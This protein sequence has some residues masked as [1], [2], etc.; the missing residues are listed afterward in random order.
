MKTVKYNLLLNECLKKDLTDL[1]AKQKERLLEKFSYLENGIWDTGVR[2]KKLKGAGGGGKVIFEAR[3]DRG[4]RLIFTL[5]R[6]SEEV[7]IYIWGAVKHDDI[8]AAARSILPD[9]A[10]FLTFEPLEEED[11]NDV[12]FDDLPDA[13][14]T[15]ESI[16]EKVKEDYGSQ[17]WLDIRDEREWQRLLAKKHPDLFEIFLYLT[18][19]QRRVLEQVP[20]VLIS[21]T[22]GSGKTT[23]A[24]YMLLKQAYDGKRLLFLTCS[25]YLKDFSQRL[26]QGLTALPDSQSRRMKSADSEGEVQFAVLTELIQNIL[27]SRGELPAPAKEVTLREFRMIF[28]KHALSRKYDPELVWEEIRSIIK[29]A[30]PP[31]NL[32]R[33]RELGIGF[34]RSKLSAVQ[35]R[36]FT[37]ALLELKNM[38]FM[39]K[40]ERILHHH[41]RYPDFDSFIRSLMEPTVRQDPGSSRVVEEILRIL[42]AKQNRFERPLLSLNE[43]LNLGRKRAPNFLYDREDIY[44]IAE[45]Y[46]KQLEADNRYDEID[47]CRMAIQALDKDRDRFLWDVVVCDEIQDFSD[48]QL[49]L[50]FRLSRLPGNL[51]CAGDTRQIIN[52]SGFRWEEVKQRFFER[53][54]NVPDVHQLALNFRS[55]G[56]IV[57]LSNAL[58]DLKQ[59][60]VGLAG[61]E[62][63]EDWKFNGRPPFVFAG[64]GQEAMLSSLGRIAAGS[65]ILV[66]TGGEQRKLKKALGTELIFTVQEAKGLEFDTVLLWKFSAEQ[67]SQGV[68]RKIAGSRNLEQEHYP[69]V[70]YEIN[71][72]YVA[73]TRSRNTLIIYDGPESA[74]VWEMEAVKPLVVT[75]S[76]RQDLAQ[77]WKQ[78]STKKE[79]G[80]Q[81]QYFYEREYYSAA[82]ECFRNADNQKM[83]DLSRAWIL[84]AGGQAGDAAVLFELHGR[85]RE[86]AEQYEHAGDYQKAAEA[87]RKAKKYDR[88]RLCA[89][90]LLEASGDYRGAASQWIKLNQ[91]DKALKAWK[92]AEAWE[93][94]AQY[95]QKQRDFTDAAEYYQRARM[96]ADAAECWKKAKQPQKAADLFFKL[97]NYDSAEKLYRK[98]REHDKLL[99]CYQGMGDS[100]KEALELERR[101]D[102]A[103][104]LAAFTRFAGSSKHNATQLLQEADAYKTPRL[105]IKAALRL[106]AAGR[107]ED[108]ADKFFAIGQFSLARDEYVRCGDLQQAGECAVV[109]GEALSAVKLF[110]QLDTPELRRRSV[111][112]LNAHAFD[113]YGYD[114]SKANAIYK[115]AQNLLS[116]KEYSRAITRMMALNM[117]EDALEICDKVSGRDEEILEYFL[118]REKY[119]YAEKVLTK[120]RSLQV[121][122]Q[123]LKQI[124]EHVQL[125]DIWYSSGRNGNMRKFGISLLYCCYDMLDKKT[126]DELAEDLMI[127]YRS[128]PLI[129]SLPSKLGE[130]ALKANSINML[131]SMLFSSFDQETDRYKEFHRKVLGYESSLPEYQVLKM[132]A[133]PADSD[134]SALG[135]GPA[136]SRGPVQVIK[137]AGGDEIEKLLAEL[138]ATEKN[139]YL[140]KNSPIQY[141]KAVT[142]LMEIGEKDRAI[143]ILQQ[144][145][146]ITEAGLLLESMGDYYEA[147]RFYRDNKRYEDAVRCCKKSGDQVGLARIY[148]RM[149]R[150]DEAVAIWKKLKKT[151]E[152]ERVRRKITKLKAKGK[153]K[154]KPEPKPRPGNGGD[155]DGE[156]NDK[157]HQLDLFE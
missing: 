76:E 155:G 149:E 49:A 117:A 127:D 23:I 20:P 3:V 4:N 85:S 58:L 103:G 77:V 61:Y 1:P 39:H 128:Y 105:Q 67:K 154:P 69:L 91:A 140:F 12:L 108:A 73:V 114:K 121:S 57:K 54:I 29:G 75:V 156:K 5:G 113:N 115:E 52:P 35:K 10:P 94:L 24:V 152:I 92:R 68:W 25:R 151:K 71:L 82:F 120:R 150:F 62:Q 142:L 146:E 9:N 31:V 129:E 17:K 78:I 110:E 80:A 60:L 40:I 104:A 100:Y 45:Y 93:E 41:T 88:A 8:S 13:Y 44:T 132:M 36:D 147:S 141:R 74:P 38:D 22:A 107:S 124:L 50:V 16:E 70:R 79:W 106:S 134:N 99:Q 95:C 47:L 131:Y 157:V 126:A 111:K 43:Y 145:R 116:S 137:P 64:I 63:R 56:S 28:S 26:Y 59:Q 37:D 86:A 109:L 27:I 138:P 51:V 66:R 33:Y 55:T 32:K 2:V 19:A 6:Q 136:R 53:G 7:C 15:Q 48:I 112:V 72:L 11:F 46:Q 130:L 143:E 30:N 87:W 83:A 97:K 148:E 101:K 65:V 102:Y 153:L 133:D 139:Y 18:I 34:I 119:D 122:P 118:S 144:H 96:D 90:H 42:E 89:V 98:L 135:R 84:A 14:F 81:G 125:S 123:W 21:G